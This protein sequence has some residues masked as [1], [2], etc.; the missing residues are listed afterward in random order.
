M[1]DI[2]SIARSGMA[3]AQTRLT[4]AASNIANRESTDFRRFQ[5]DSREQPGGGVSARLL[6]DAE[7]QSGDGLSTDLVYSIEA[8]QAFAANVKV[9]KAQDELLGGLLDTRA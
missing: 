1:S 9:L 6:R 8:R 4:A 3:A 7:P 2:A 5:V